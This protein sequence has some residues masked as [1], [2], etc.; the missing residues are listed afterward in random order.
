[1]GFL[2]PDDPRLLATLDG[3][4][5]VL[6]RGGLVERHLPTEDR[7]DDPCGPFVFASFWV[8]Q[9]LERCGRDGSATFA[10]AAAA[11]GALDLFGEVA[12]PV[13]GSPLGNY[14]QVQ[15]H[16]SFVLAATRP[17]PV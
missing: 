7:S 2:A 3:I 15:S 14:P 10:A 8:A 1:M 12:N 5:A 17:H 4:T 9:A 16:A 6:D 11:R 13:D